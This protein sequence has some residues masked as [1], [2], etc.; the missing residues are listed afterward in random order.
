[1]APWVY[2]H[3]RD[4]L[5]IFLAK[6]Y[7]NKQFNVQTYESI[8]ANLYNNNA[9]HKEDGRKLIFI[10]SWKSLL[11]NSVAGFVS[12]EATLQGCKKSFFKIRI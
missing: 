5:S 4:V 6:F 11:T 9:R 1:M 12:L 10:H 8:P 2:P 7:L 3:G